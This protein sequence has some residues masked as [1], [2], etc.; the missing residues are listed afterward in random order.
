MVFQTHGEPCWRRGIGEEVICLGGSPL[1]GT[2]AASP[3]KCNQR[4]GEHET[5]RIQVLKSGEDQENV[6]D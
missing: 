2:G 3:K 1:H 5:Q 6:E 4:V